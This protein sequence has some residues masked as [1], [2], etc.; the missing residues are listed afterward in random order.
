M[1]KELDYPSYSSGGFQRISWGAVFAGAFVSLAVLVV[2]TSLGA[3]I[4][5]ASAPSAAA[6]NSG[7]SVAKGFGVG[8]AF[9]MLLS[10]VIAFYCGG[11]IA[12]R[13]ATGVVLEADFF[14]I[15]LGGRCQILGPDPPEFP[16]R[17]RC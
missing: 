12:G 11:W 3:G 9:W 8:S 15:C 1:I 6:S 10:G 2:L 17:A 4:G 13:P 5:L 7:A 14:Q 16:C